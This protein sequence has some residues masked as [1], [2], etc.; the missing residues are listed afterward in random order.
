MDY[1]NIPYDFIKDNI[2][3]NNQR[4]IYH[5]KKKNYIIYKR[6]IKNLK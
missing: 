4:I 2:K 5:K 1:I 6:I 3:D